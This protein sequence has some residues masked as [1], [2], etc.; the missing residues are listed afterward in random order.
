MDAGVPGRGAALLLVSTRHETELVGP[1]CD[2]ADV[3]LV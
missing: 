3:R 1:V 2:N